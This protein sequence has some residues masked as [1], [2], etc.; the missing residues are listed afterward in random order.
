MLNLFSAVKLVKCNS[1]FHLL[2]FSTCKEVSY[3]FDPRFNY[4]YLFFF[5][6]VAM[7]TFRDKH[8]QVLK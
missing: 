7:E 4:F 5:Y 6:N 8:Y 3:Y 1:V 2:V